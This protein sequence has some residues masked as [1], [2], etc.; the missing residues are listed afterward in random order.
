MKRR[1]M[2]KDID[3]D[4]DELKREEDIEEQGRGKRT[5]RMD[6]IFVK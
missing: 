3:E 1:P 5:V 4:Y 2:S 6:K